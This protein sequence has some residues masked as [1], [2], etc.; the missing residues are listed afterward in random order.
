[1]S[2][3]T[4]PYTAHSAA[5]S[6]ADLCDHF[7]ESIAVC[8]VP[9]S[10]FGARRT[11]SGRLACLRTFEDAALLRQMLGQPGEGR[12]LVVDGGG[13]LKAALLGENMA[14]LGAMNGWKGVVVNGAVRDVE[15]LMQIDFAVLALGRSPRRGGKVGTGAQDIEVSFGGVTFVPGRFLCLDSDGLVVM[16]DEPAGTQAQS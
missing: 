6:T 16:P 3:V 15:A 4:D 8:N 1:M 11:A 10:S 7:G 12:I 5:P 14:R 13:S 2:E 9:L